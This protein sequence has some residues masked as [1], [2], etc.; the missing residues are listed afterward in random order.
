MIYL[1]V[2][3]FILLLIAGLL[4]LILGWYLTRISAANSRASLLSRL[5]K[6]ESKAREL[7]TELDALATAKH[8]CD[9]ERR[10]LSDELADLR[11]R[12]DAAP[13]PVDT[14]KAITVLQDELEQCREALVAASA[15]A[16]EHQ[17]VTAAPIASAAATPASGM[18][19]TPPAT[20]GEG[21]TA[22]DLQQ[23]RGI[24]PK[25]A[26]ILKELGIERFEQI[27]GWTPENIDWVNAHL[28][29]KGRVEREE[30]IPQAKAL[31][32]AR[33]T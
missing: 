16:V 2:Q 7:R 26:G 31:M 17:E 30:W 24:G 10:L 21:G 20:A 12:E 1:I 11:A 32:A 13:D 29:F 28:R 4:G 15:G 8:N 14:D 33:D 25:I 19:G 6:A 3:T 23:I 18:A 22:D 9:S 27:A 5:T